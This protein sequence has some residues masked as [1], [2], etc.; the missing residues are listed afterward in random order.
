MSWGLRIIQGQSPGALL[1]LQAA[2]ALPRAAGPQPG[3]CAAAGGGR[4]GAPCVVRLYF[5]VYDCLCMRP[6]F[7][8]SIA[9]LIVDAVLAHPVW[10][11][12]L[13]HAAFLLVFEHRCFAGGC[14]V[15]SSVVTLAL[16]ACLVFCPSVAVPLV[17]S[18]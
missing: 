15:A 10:Q 16:A 5:R 9:T 11:G 17:L 4:A 18:P 1:C 7:F 3:G 6:G 12:L 2:A 13:V 8:L 14:C